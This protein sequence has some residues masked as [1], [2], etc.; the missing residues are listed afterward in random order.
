MRKY[1]ITYSIIIQFIFT[2]TTKYVS[3]FPAL[4]SILERYKYDIAFIIFLLVEH[5]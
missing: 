1:A 4:P 5:L 3:Q 2:E